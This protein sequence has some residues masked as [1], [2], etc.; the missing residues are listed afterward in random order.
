MNASTMASKSPE[1]FKAIDAQGLGFELFEAAMRGEV[2]LSDFVGCFDL[3]TPQPD[4]YIDVVCAARRLAIDLM[5]HAARN[6]ERRPGDG[7]RVSLGRR[8]P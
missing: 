3:L 6:L 4:L 8:R 1:S 2:A 7:R 5:Q